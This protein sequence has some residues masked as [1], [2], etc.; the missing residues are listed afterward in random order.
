MIIHQ[1]SERLNYL[2]TTP[3]KTHD[4]YSIGSTVKLY[5]HN[6]KWSQIQIKKAQDN[7]YQSLT[8]GSQKQFVEALSPKR[9]KSVGQKNRKKFP[10][11][12][13]SAKN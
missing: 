10:S 6:N 2:E 7:A 9:L 5:A 11:V 12:M 8:D 3:K 1:K 4:L 13:R